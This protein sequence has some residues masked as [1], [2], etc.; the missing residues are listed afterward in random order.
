[1]PPLVNKAAQHSAWAWKIL[2]VKVQLLLPLQI[3]DL[4]LVSR[5][6]RLQAEGVDKKKLLGSS[7]SMQR[8][9]TD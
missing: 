5:C 2:R 1:M 4:E 6:A 9:A 8:V 3:E 7:L